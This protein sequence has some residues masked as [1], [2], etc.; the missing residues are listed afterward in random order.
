MLNHLTHSYSYSYFCTNSYLMEWHV[1]NLSLSY[2]ACRLKG[3]GSVGYHFVL[4]HHIPQ[5][6]QVDQQAATIFYGSPPS[7][8]LW[9]M[10]LS[11]EWVQPFIRGVKDFMVLA[12]FNHIYGSLD[13]YPYLELYLDWVYS[14][15]CIFQTRA[16]SKYLKLKFE[17]KL[18][19]HST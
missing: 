14:P 13:L 3:W 5:V 8:C 10:K 17:F 4:I 18:E 2:S 11:F 1:D 12:F 9:M 19:N 6:K 16:N 15:C 7:L